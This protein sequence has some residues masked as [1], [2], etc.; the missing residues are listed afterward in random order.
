MAWVNPILSWTKESTYEAVDLNRVENN[1]EHISNLL[2]QYG[3]ASGIISIIKNRTIE[4]YDDITSINRVESNINK[5][6]NCFYTPEG[7]QAR[8]TWIANMKFDY[9]D[10]FRYENNLN[11]LFNLANTLI[12][13]LKYTGTFSSGQ[14]VIL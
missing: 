10:A 1:T 8:K 7:W 6:K 12:D 9:T 3:Y 4:S 13:N 11:M 14:E 5:L 2:A